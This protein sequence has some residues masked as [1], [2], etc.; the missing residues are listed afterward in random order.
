MI[1]DHRIYRL[2]P[3]RASAQL[4]LYGK[5]GYPVQLRYMGE[6]HYYLLSET[7]QMNTLLHGWIY[8]SAGDREAKRAAMAK[9]PDWKHFVSENAK[10]GNDINNDGSADDAKLATG[11]YALSQ[12]LNVL[13][14]MALGK[15]SANR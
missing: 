11:D 14:G 12:A 2:H 15:T 3:G 7:G 1:I 6:P 4:E 9:D 8:E 13:K 10:A 5:L